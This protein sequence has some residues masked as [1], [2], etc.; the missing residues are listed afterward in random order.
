[1]AQHTRQPAPTRFVEASG[2]HFVYRRFGKPD[3]VSLVF[4][5]QT[6]RLGSAKEFQ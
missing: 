2:I 4:S 3:G 1:M 6:G 5:Q